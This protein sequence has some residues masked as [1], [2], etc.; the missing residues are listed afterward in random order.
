MNNDK[1]DAIVEAILDYVSPVYVVG[2]L[3]SIFPKTSTV[4]SATVPQEELNI[5]NGRY[6]EWLL[7]VKAKSEGDDNI[8]IITDFDKLSTEEQ[9]FYLDI[10]CEGIVSSESLP[11][12]LRLLIVADKKTELIPK[13]RES[14]NYFELI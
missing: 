2:E 11:E 1:I 4:I 13:I 5:I 8:L 6:P 14:V 12:N 3:K 9:K 7:S 10:I